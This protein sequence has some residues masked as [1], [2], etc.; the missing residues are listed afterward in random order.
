MTLSP[1]NNDYTEKR[2]KQINSGTK[3]GSDNI[4]TLEQLPSESERNPKKINEPYIE[5]I[6][7]HNPVDQAIRNN[8]GL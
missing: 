6:S 4:A 1:S 8:T 3:E 5:K 2:T 7:F